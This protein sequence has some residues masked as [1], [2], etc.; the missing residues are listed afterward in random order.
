MT[1]TPQLSIRR[2]QADDLPAIVRLLADDDL[3]R[4]RERLEEPLAPCYFAAFTLIDRDP[5]QHLVVVEQAGAI[6]G[7]LQLTVLPGLSHQGSLRAQIESVRVDSQF[8]GHGIGYRL[9]TWA[10]ARAREEG[11]SVVQ[12][13]THNQRGDAHRFY[14][15]LGFVASHVGMKL[16]LS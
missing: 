15:R 16:V 14:A 1:E 12:L 3:G 5:R 8:R 11:C 9:M 10:I 6:I 13:T 7:T 2:A 4:L